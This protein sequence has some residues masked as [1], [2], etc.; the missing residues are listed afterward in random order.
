MTVTY[1]LTV[2]AEAD[3]RDVIRY[4]RKHWGV[5]QARSYAAKLT[6]GIERLATEHGASKNLAAIYP[7]L[8]M[9]HCEHHYIFCLVRDDLPALVVAI[10]HENMDLMTRLSNRLT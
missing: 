7:G 9:V 4:T 3:I 1:V 2:A 5:D 8:R 10:F 6:H